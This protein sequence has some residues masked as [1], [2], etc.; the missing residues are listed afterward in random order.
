MAGFDPLEDATT[1]QPDACGGTVTISSS[2]CFP[3][4]NLPEWIVLGI[5]WIM[6]GIKEGG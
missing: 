5:K 4:K 1:A 2:E 6:L 3:L